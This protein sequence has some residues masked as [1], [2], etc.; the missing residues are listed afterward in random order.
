MH[1]PT[2]EIPLSRG[3]L[4]KLLF[5]CTIFIVAGLWLAV[6]QPQTSNPILNS[7]ILKYGVGMMGVL[8]GLIGVFAFLTK[9]F[10]TKAGITIDQ[11]GLIENA[12]TLSV[13]RI[14]WTD[15]LDIRE[16]T[17][18]GSFS[19]KEKFIIIMVRNPDYYISKQKNAIRRKLMMLNAK[20]SGSPL[21]IT[22]NGLKIRHTELKE[23]LQR[24]LKEYRGSND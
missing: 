14:P 13:G 19:A 7:S 11:T 3:K 2:I 23:L 12:S 21:Y 18:Q 20:K 15:I 10:D 16:T 1:N 17:V 4:I 6:Y 24:K 22:T 9:I 5:F 8:M